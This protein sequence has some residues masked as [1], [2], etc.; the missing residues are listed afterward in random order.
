MP[1]VH[2]LVMTVAM[3]Q[4]TRPSITFFVC[5]MSVRCTNSDHTSA[6]LTMSVH[7]GAEPSHVST[8][9]YGLVQYPPF[10]LEVAYTSTL[11]KGEAERIP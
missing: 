2:L 8:A 11:Y 7:V 9:H 6:T 3:V 4:R 10:G 5:L 1:D